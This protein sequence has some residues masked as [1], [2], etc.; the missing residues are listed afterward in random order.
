[1]VDGCAALAAWDGRKTLESRGAHVFRE[2]WRTARLIPVAPR[3]AFDVTDQLRLFSNKQWPELPFHA[4]D[5]AKARGGR[6]AEVDAAVR[7]WRRAGCARLLG[8]SLPKR[9]ETHAP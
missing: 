6:G 7:V 4:D 5:V 9:V 3:N 8:A 2:F 1:M